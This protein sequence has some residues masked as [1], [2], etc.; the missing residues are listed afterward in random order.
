ME[1]QEWA[2]YSD[3]ELSIVQIITQHEVFWFTEA[4]REQLELEV[5]QELKMEVI[6]EVRHCWEKV[7]E[8]MELCEKQ[9]VIEELLGKKEPVQY[10]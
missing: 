2:V 10:Q 9:R 7:I 4:I 6:R 8:L 1:W 5:T 3:L